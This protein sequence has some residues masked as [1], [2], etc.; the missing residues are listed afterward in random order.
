MKFLKKT[1]KVRYWQVGLGALAMLVLG[2][3]W[4]RPPVV[5]ETQKRTAVKRVVVKP[6]PAVTP[7][8]L[9]EPRDCWTTEEL[10]KY[11]LQAYQAGRAGCR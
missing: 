8:V 1:L 7:L 4:L 11:L 3:G 9:V 10:K 6:K 2:S 5:R